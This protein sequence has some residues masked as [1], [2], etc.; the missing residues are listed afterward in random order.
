MAVKLDILAFKRVPFGGSSGEGDIVMIGFGDWSGATFKME[1]RAQP[2]DTGTA[3]VSLTNASLG[4]QGMNAI[5]SPSYTDPDTG[6]PVAATIIRPQINETTMEGL[7]SAARPSERLTL[8][9]D[10]HV[11]PPGEN[12]RV[13]MYGKF[14]VDPGVTI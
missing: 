3:L 11:T 7:P 9:Y 5:Y 14:V 12:K 8:Y 2:G 1:V 4:A 13:V 10:L 6:L